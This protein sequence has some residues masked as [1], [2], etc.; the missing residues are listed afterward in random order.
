MTTPAGT[1][2]TVNL[3]AD[4]V[5]DQESN[6][7]ITASAVSAGSGSV[8]LSSDSLSL[9]YTPASGFSGSTTLSYTLSDGT[10]TVSNTIAI[11]VVNPVVTSAC[12]PTVGLGASACSITP[13]NHAMRVLAFGLC[14]A[15]PTR[16]TATVAYDLSNC[17]LIYD[18]RASGGV[19]VSV[20]GGGSVN[21]GGALTVPDYGTYT[22]GIVLVDNT[23]TVQGELEL[24][25]GATP[26]CYIEAGMTVACY[27]TAQTAPQVTDTV[28][29]FF[30]LTPAI[31]NYTFS[32]DAVTVDLVTSESAVAPRSTSDAASDAILA[33]QTFASP[34]TFSASSR[35]IDIGVKVSEA[36]TMTNTVADT[37]PFSIRFTVE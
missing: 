6:T 21:F 28:G 32:D 5:T 1:D 17:Q 37:S 19:S 7:V 25:A 16:P 12:S 13:T 35:A 23:F 9:T 24:S 18:G 34:Q 29:N 30:D 10:T 4:Y 20:A 11:S 22:H 31:Y 27:A 8:A 3:I 26:Y 33:I 14:T 2:L 36:V 15:A